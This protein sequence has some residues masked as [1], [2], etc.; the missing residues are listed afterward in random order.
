MATW[1]KTDGK[2]VQVQPANARKGFTLEELY[3]YTNGGPIEIV[4]I[5]GPS[6]LIMVV[7]E[8]GKLTPLPYNHEA[9]MELGTRDFIHGDVLICKDKEVK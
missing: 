8:E 9:T 4:A 2:R 7:N 3:R 1:I 5:A 6:K